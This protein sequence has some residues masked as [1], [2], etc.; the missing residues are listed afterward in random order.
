[1]AI[2]TTSPLSR[3]ALV[4][5]TLGAI[6]AA[7][8]GAVARPLQ[9]KAA[10]TSLVYTNDENNSVVLSASSIANGPGTGQGIGVDGHSDDSVG[11]RGTSGSNVGVRGS[12][13]SSYGVYAE[14]QSHHAIAGTA[15]RASGSGAPAAPTW[16]SGGSRRP[17]AAG[18]SRARRRRSAWAHRQ[19]ARI[20]PAVLPATCSWTS[21]AVSGSARA[22]R[23]G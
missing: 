3:R 8:A 23:P 1:M 15:A 2:D 19:G 6:A 22:A 5:G 18:C 7:L 13:D 10:D 9:V 16:A 4:G 20:P 11:V 21:R 12:S 17:G 14:S